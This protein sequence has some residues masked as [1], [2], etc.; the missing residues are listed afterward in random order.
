[1]TTEWF[2]LNM[3]IEEYAL[4]KHTRAGYNRKSL[5]M[6]ADIH[7]HWSLEMTTDGYS[8]RTL[9]MSTTTGRSGWQAVL[10]QLPRST[11][12]PV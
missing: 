10:P 4:H 2:S 8:N 7:H 11:K 5:E 9:R 1:M 12:K 3:T 6:T